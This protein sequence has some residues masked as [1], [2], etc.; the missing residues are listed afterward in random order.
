MRYYISFDTKEYPGKLKATYIDIGQEVTGDLIKKFKINLCDDPAYKEL[1][2]YVLNN[3]S[4]KG[5]DNE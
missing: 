3:P 1:E 4:K 5:K 2:Q